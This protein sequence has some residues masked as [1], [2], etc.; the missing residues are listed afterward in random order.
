MTCTRSYKIKFVKVM[1]RLSLLAL[2]SIGLCA[3]SLIGSSD[4]I[5]DSVIKI[6]DATRLVPLVQGNQWTLERRQ[7]GGE[8]NM[9]YTATV[10][11]TVKLR[12]HIYHQYVRR[13]IS[14]AVLSGDDYFRNT[15][16]GT[17]TLYHTGRVSDESVFLK[18]PV[19]DGET[20]QYTD[21]RGIT[22]TY[23]VERKVVEVPAGNFEV[24]VYS[25]YDP[26][27]TVAVHPGIG[28]IKISSPVG[29]DVLVSYDIQD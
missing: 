2:L 18:Y 25:G 26:S 15:S 11:D 5:E 23:Q 29:S 9:R 7:N 21:V 4:Q 22:F 17:Y 14:G 1:T 27:T 12:G 16:R 10:G 20:Y 6:S 28:I 3:C 19:E 8:S 24:Y 13:D